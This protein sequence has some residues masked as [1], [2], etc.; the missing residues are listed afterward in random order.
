[1]ATPNSFYLRDIMPDFVKKGLVFLYRMTDYNWHHKLYLYGNY[2]AYM[3]F[4]IAFT[5]I[6]SISPMYL[7]T[8]ENIIKIYVCLAL[9]IRF[10]PFVQKE[11]ITRNINYDRHLGFSAGVFLLFTTVFADITKKYIG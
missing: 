3:L 2:A 7:S 5:G 6:I 10:N 8:L 9:L 11:H 1:M 4:L